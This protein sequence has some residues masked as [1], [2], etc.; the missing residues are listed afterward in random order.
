M[1]LNFEK[2]TH[3]GVTSMVAPFVA[4]LLSVGTT[5]L[6]SNNDKG[7]E[8]HVCN[9][10]FKGKNVAA[11][12]YNK[13]PEDLKVDGKVECELSFQEG[14]DTPYFRVLWNEGGER[15]SKNDLIEMGIQVPTFDE[16]SET[17]EG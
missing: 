6:T 4:T 1:D 8:F 12:T 3:N 13:A 16:V 9:I 11:I 5:T 2:R 15:V 7:T 17:V 14:D 10:D